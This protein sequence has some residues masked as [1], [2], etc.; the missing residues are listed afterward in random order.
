MT[1]KLYN[2]RKFKQI[3]MRIISLKTI[4][5]YVEQHPE[6]ETAFQRWAEIV[7][8]AHWKNFADVKKD[9]STVDN[10]GNQHYVFNIKGN[11]FRLIVVIQFTPQF[12]LIRLV[13]T[14][15]EYYKIPD[16]SKL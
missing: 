9:F 8:K 6:S 3:V 16:F 14:H 13:V 10:V 11:D 1:K 2:C 4:K 15:A 7:S 12:V 5:N